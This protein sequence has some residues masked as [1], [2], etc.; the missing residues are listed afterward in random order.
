MITPSQLGLLEDRWR[1]YTERFRKA[2]E[3]RPMQ[4]LK[5][6]HSLRVAGEARAIASGEGWSGDDVRLAEAIGLLHDTARF[7]QFEIYRTF[8]DT[9]SIDHG[10]LG[11]RTLKEEGFLDG[12][13]DEARTLILHSV[14]HHNKKELPRL[15]SA[16]EEKH[17]RLIRDAD[18]LD[19]FFIGW[20]ALNSGQIHDHPEL[21]MN[22]DFAGPPSDI[23]LDQFERGETLDYRQI[24]TLADRFVLLLSW[25]HDL[26]YAASRRL[27]CERNILDRFLDVLP[28]KTDRMLNG[29]DLTAVFL[30]SDGHAT[31]PEG[32]PPDGKAD[33]KVDGRGQIR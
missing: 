17:L 32:T 9:E 29:F 28:V 6:E 5:L 8:N 27:V 16:H 1:R 7:P 4:Q 26:S 22:I 18:R 21:M 13:S 30:E 23:I 20:E 3:L 15:L 19:I 12:L 14:Q 11:A 10:D 25:M 33:K 2:G 24:H 31:S